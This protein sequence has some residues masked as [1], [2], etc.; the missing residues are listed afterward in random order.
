MGWIAGVQFLTEARFFLYFTTFRLSL[1]SNQSPIQWVPGVISPGIKC[2]EHEADHSYPFSAEVKNGGAI[3]PLPHKS[4]WLGA[5][6]INQRDNFY[7][8]PLYFINL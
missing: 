6:L 3:S 8:L 2:P 5:S 1:G 7:L 4:P